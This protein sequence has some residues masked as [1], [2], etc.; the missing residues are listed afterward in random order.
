[1]TSSTQ[2]EFEQTPGN[3]EGQGSLAT[4]SPWD[5]R[6]SNMTE[7]LNNIEYLVFRD[8]LTSLSTVSLNEV[9]PCCSLCQNFLP[10][11]ATIM[12]VFKHK[13]LSFYGK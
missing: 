4:C 11:T 12:P 5:H 1:M 6:E 9:H 10:F 13:N 8:W 2:H 7:E 3:N